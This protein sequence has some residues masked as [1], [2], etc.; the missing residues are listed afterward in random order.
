MG[1]ALVH[2]RAGLGVEAPAVTVEVHLGGGLPRISLV[3]LPETAVREA[4][5]RVK[6]AL[7]NAGF[8]FPQRHITISLAPADLPKEGS[9]FDLPIALGILAANADV[10]DKLFRNFEFVGELSLCGDLNPVKGVLPAALKAKE[11][12][13]GLIVPVGN[14]AEAALAKGPAQYEAPS[15]LSVVAWLN[16]RKSLPATV[17]DN[18]STELPHKD[19]ADVVG[20][21][22]ARRALEVAAAGGHNILLT[23]P[24][25]TGKTMLASRLPGI[26]PPL[27]EQEALEA[28]SVSSIASAGLI[29]NTGKPAVSGRPTIQQ[30]PS[31]WSAAA[32]N[33]APGKYP[34]PITVSCSWMNCRSSAG[35][36]WKCFANRWSQD[37]S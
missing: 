5:D 14:G 16:G 29:S 33:L 10:P 18:T 3:G 31:H 35:M 26:L 20:Q 22:F 30:A 9:R 11:S 24:P 23:G 2:S 19:M 8:K 37:E 32:P 7:L 12:G 17:A 4:K 21:S 1:L 28:A 6:A 25:G 34:W 27:T 36:C 15:L 13:R